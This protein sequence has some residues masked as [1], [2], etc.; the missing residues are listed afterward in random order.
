MAQRA[1][2]YLKNL[3]TTGKKPAQV[4][5][6]DWLDSYVHKDDVEQ[7]NAA[8]MDER[9]NNY[10]ES[11]RAVMVGPLN[12]L[13]GVLQLLDGFQVTDNLKA[14]LDAAS[15]VVSWGQ[16]E[17]RPDALNVTWEE[18]TISLASYSPAA[19]TSPEAIQTV[20]IV[21][22]IGN[23]KSPNKTVITDI[24][25]TNVTVQWLGVSFPSFIVTRIQWVKVGVNPKITLP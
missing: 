6:H 18:Q 13:G 1:V 10:D 4:D 14:L 9:I 3:F 2:E 7:I 15:G 11:L 5:Y 24:G 21:S 19:P 12:N 17:N 16:I 20:S 25:I 8:T 23:I 22:G